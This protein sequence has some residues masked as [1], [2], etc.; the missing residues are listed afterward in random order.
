VSASLAARI[1]IV[2][3]NIRP[4]AQNWQWLATE[5]QMAA[6]AEIE[7]TQQNTVSP[8]SSFAR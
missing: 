8:I 5:R 1:R 7:S 3:P 6:R 4:S 2:S